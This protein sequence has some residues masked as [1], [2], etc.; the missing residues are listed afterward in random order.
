SSAKMRS[1]SCTT[2]IGRCGP[3]TTSRPFAFNSLRL[4]ARTKSV[5][6]VSIAVFLGNRRCRGLGSLL[7]FHIGIYPPSLAGNVDAL[8]RRSEV[9]FRGRTGAYRPQALN[10]S[11]PHDQGVVLSP[12]L[13]GA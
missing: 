7:P 3:C 10:R 5:V 6:G 4:P 13:Q 9:R 8:T 1:L 12:R 11:R 2:R